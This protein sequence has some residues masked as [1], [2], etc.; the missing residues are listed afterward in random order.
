MTS[1]ARN[2][3]TDAEK[4][5]IHEMH[6]AGATRNDIARDLNRSGDTIS[7]YCT[8]AGLDFDRDKVRAATE[9]RKA[10]LALMRADL[11]ARFLAEANAALDVIGQPETVWN[12]GGRD[13]TYAEHTFLSPTPGTRRAMILAASA[14]STQEIRIAQ[15]DSGANV[16]AAKSLLTGLAEALGVKGPAEQAPADDDE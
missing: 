5:R 7:R 1:R 3:L 4:A 9:A 16:E 14:A 6:T 8:K 12:F 15:A 10:D 11:R 13:N 2:P